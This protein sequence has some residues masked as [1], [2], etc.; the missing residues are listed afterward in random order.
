[1]SGFNGKWIILTAAAV[2][3]GAGCQQVRERFEPPE[4]KRA[5]LIAAQC[6]EL[7][8]SIADLDVKIEK[9]RTEYEQQLREKD[10]EL[11]AYRRRI[12][13]VQKDVQETMTERVNQVTAAVLN[14]NA[15]LRKEV[16]TL[17]AQV[18]QGMRTAQQRMDNPPQQ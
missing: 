7:E 9:V 14:E 10:A 16:E 6:L 11:A 18:E 3:V 8:R 13:S 4:G 15:R 12:E 17:R 2:L 1:M 5:R